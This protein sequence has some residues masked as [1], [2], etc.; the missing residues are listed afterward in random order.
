MKLLT[1]VVSSM[2]DQTETNCMEITTY[3]CDK[4]T[5]ENSERYNNDVYSV[6]ICVL[7]DLDLP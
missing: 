5:H 7:C 2:L 1:I 4:N 3:K 6:F